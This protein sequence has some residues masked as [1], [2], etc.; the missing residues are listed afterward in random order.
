MF[1]G[2]WLVKNL[3]TKYKYRIIKIITINCKL[4]AYNYT[5]M[6]LNYHLSMDQFTLW[7]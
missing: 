3:N 6:L 7:F 1:G 5:K 4:N 2:I